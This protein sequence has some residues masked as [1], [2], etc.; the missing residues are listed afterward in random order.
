M[1]CRCRINHCYSIRCFS[2]NNSR[3][4]GMQPM[5]HSN[6]ILCCSRHAIPSVFQVHKHFRLRLVSLTSLVAW[7]PA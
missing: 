3:V 1:C 6:R 2:H 4:H 7:A 5:T